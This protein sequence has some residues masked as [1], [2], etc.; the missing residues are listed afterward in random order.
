MTLGRTVGPPSKDRLERML[1]D[2][3]IELIG[4]CGWTKFL[5]AVRDVAK[6][7]GRDDLVSALDACQRAAER[8]TA[9]VKRIMG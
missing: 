1:T 5:A 3:I 9:A 6:L 7:I 2:T 4:I 8:T